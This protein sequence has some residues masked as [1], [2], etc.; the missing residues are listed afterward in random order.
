MQ[1]QYNLPPLPQED[2]SVTSLMNDPLPVV[3]ILAVR[4]SEED[5]E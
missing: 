5:G 2:E 1:L 4:M 3:G